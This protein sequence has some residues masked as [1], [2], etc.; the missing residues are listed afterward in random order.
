MSTPTADKEW[1]G[2]EARNDTLACV[3]SIVDTVRQPLVVLDS[4]LRVQS[5]NR[6]FYR[7]FRV[8]PQETAGR[9]LYDLG[10]GQWDIPGLRTSLEEVLSQNTSF[11]DF[12][13]ERNFPDIG[14]KVMLLNARQLRPEGCQRILLAIEDVTERRRAEAALERMRVLL[15]E[16]QKIGHLGSFE[17]VAATRTTV[18]SEEE[19]RLYGLD[20]AGP[21]PTYDM[22]LQKC[23]HPADAA[24]LHETFTKAMRS[25]AV[26]ELE[27]RIVR[28]DG[29]VRWVYD[30]AH[31]YFDE[32]GELV[33][34]IGT[35]LDISARKEAEDALRAADRR[36]EEFIAM[37]AH[38][39]RNPL[40]PLRTGL[41]LLALSGEDPAEVKQVSAMMGRQVDYLTRLV[42]DLLDVSRISRGKIKLH[43]ELVDLCEVV[44]AAVEMAGPGRGGG[45]RRLARSLPSRPLL[46]EG[47]RVRLTQV[48]GNLLTNAVK[49]TAENGQIGLAVEEQQ[50]EARICVRDDGAGIAPD[51]LDGIFDLFAQADP[52]KGGGLGIGLALARRLIELHGG[53]IEARSGGPGTGSEFII[54][55]PLANKEPARQPRKAQQSSTGIAGRRILVVD[56]NRDVATS[57]AMVLR[58]LGAKV[59]VAYDGATALTE[60]EADPP[61]VVL[62]DIGMPGMDGY[63]VARR[64]REQCRNPG[65]LLIAM[66]GWGDEEAQERVRAAGFDH[67]LVK[68][69]TTDSLRA[70]L[71]R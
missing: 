41:E 8:S 54:S 25:R 49:F 13:V 70:L 21:S 16:G 52:A 37:L 10:N 4:R 65:L 47:D 24:L 59:H 23:I 53:K 71:T 69:T 36:K 64:M 3:R 2:D 27:H 28:P 46:V 20:P 63:E 50:G 51:Q 40:A 30:R 57:T 58:H 15:E 61:D 22:L 32:H 56:D 5:A 60:L 33:R 11:D 67:H 55:L 29:S 35:T 6:S 44:G 66:T 68:P 45:A 12:E 62:L 26:Y 9:L 14:R 19:Y 38:E 7:T 39:L 48:I 1:S 18:W 34:Y 42:D 31:P 17:Y 43:T